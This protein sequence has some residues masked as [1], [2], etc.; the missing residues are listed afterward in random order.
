MIF[1]AAIASPIWRGLGFWSVTPSRLSVTSPQTIANDK[2]RKN[3][4]RLSAEW[5]D[6][7]AASPCYLRIRMKNTD[8]AQQIARETGISQGAAADQL[9]EVVTSILKSLKKGRSADL[10]GLGRFRRDINGGLRFTQ[11]PQKTQASQKTQTPQK[12]GSN[13]SR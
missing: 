8:L 12:K 11:A 4:S 9:D 10:P 13:G 6:R 5:G 1:L 2:K 7:L 3:K